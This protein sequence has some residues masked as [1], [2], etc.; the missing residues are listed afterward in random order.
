MRG[1]LKSLIEALLPI[2]NI[3]AYAGKTGRNAKPVTCP[4]EHPRVCG[5]NPIAQ[6]N[7]AC[8]IGT[9]PRMRGKLNINS[10]GGDAMRNIPAYAGKT[11]ILML[12]LMLAKEHPR[13]CGENE[14]RGLSTRNNSGTSPRMRGK[15]I[16]DVFLE[17][18]VRNIPA[19]AGK[20]YLDQYMSLAEEEH[21]RVCGEN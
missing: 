13:V 11:A 3:P 20:T 21:P 18:R 4:E 16:E 14:A 2:R 8:K 12:R 6:S 17:L 1:K 5:E 19:Y 9:S 15:L 10:Y 7:G